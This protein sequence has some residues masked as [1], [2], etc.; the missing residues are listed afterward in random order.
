MSIVHSCISFIQRVYVW[1]AFTIS[2]ARKANIPIL[3]VYNMALSSDGGYDGAHYH[4]YVF[5]KAEEQLLEYV[6]ESSSKA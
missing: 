5:K 2:K 3:D 1:N 4:D 6:L